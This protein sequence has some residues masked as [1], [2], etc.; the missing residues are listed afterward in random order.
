MTDKECPVSSERFS[1]IEAVDE[2]ISVLR[3]NAMAWGLLIDSKTNERCSCGT[4]YVYAEDFYTTMLNSSHE[5]A[6]RLREALDVL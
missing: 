4:S 2:A 3:S 6:E 5:C 1:A